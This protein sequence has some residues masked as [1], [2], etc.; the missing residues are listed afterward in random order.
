MI[1]KQPAR[2]AAMFDAIAGAYDFLNHLLSAGSDRRW[3][4]HA[5]KALA[6]SGRETVLDVCAGT[7]DFGLEAL[8]PGGGAARV[9]GVDFSRGMLERGRRKARR[10]GAAPTLHLVQGDATRLPI[11]SASVQAVLVAFGLRN[12]EALEASLEEI[13]RVLASDGKL[14]ILEFAMPERGPLRTVYL[15]YFTRLLPAIGRLVS[16]H[17]S[18][19]AY[20]PASVHAFPPPREF[21]SLLECHGFF[22]VISD[23]LTGGIVYLH[24]GTKQPSDWPR[25]PAGRGSG[26]GV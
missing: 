6:L 9:I 11:R 24:M 7:A 4:R 22:N 20:L 2:I 23:P 5:V 25:R 16:G 21:R 13:H 3:R 15:F 17:P 8:A 19:Y 1:D 26:R 12:V 18:A 10:R 14:A